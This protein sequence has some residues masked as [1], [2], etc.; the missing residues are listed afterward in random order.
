M[1]EYDESSE[2][3]IA[4]L[5]NVI[6]T[7]DEVMDGFEELAETV[8]ENY[9]ARLD[10]IADF[11]ISEGICDVFGE[12]TPDEIKD[13]LGVPQIDI[14]NQIITYTDHTFDEEHIISFDYDDR[15]LGGFMYLSID[16]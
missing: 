3:Y 16:G 14:G 6:V 13:G 15:E 2:L 4:D 8:A 1:F 10:D 5:D 9:A 7:C 11:L 12:L